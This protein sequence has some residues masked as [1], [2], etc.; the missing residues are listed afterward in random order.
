MYSFCRLAGVVDEVQQAA[1]GR[2]YSDPSNIIRFA[3]QAKTHRKQ[4]EKERKTNET[5]GRAPT[6]LSQKPHPY[7][8]IHF[9]VWIFFPPWTFFVCVFWDVLKAPT[10]NAGHS[11]HHPEHKQTRIAYTHTQCKE[12]VQQKSAVQNNGPRNLNLNKIITHFSDEKRCPAAVAHTQ[13]NSGE[14]V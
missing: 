13:S 4:H 12:N 3:H 5:R 10:C 1:A 6:H 11:K 9:L 8:A 2:L 14:S 7:A